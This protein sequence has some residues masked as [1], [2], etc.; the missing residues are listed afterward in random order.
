[1][2]ATGEPGGDYSAAVRVVSR[3]SLLAGA[4]GL[5]GTAL[6]GSAL[7]ACTPGDVP[8][9]TTPTTTPTGGPPVVDEPALPRIAVRELWHA[10]QRT[11]LGYVWCSSTD[12]GMVRAVDRSGNVCSDP[13]P[14]AAARAVD[15]HHLV[16]LRLSGTGGSADD[17]FGVYAI[18]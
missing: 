2:S 12:D 3:R 6:A 4:V 8:A 16:V 17:G 11:G 18:G 7:T 5:T 10:P 15:D 1:M 9:P 14:G 13:V